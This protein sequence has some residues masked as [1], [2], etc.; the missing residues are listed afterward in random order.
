MRNALRAA[1]V[2]VVTMLAISCNASPQN[3]G[4]QNA[5]LSE[6]EKV[7]AVAA[8]SEASQHV[9]RRPNI[10]VIMADD[11]GYSD[12]AP[13]GGEISTPNLSRL[14][15]EGV[16]FTNFYV[17]PACS[18]TRSMFLSGVDHHVAG[19]GN[20]EFNIQ[21]PQRGRP[22]YEGYLNDSVVSFASLLNDAGYQTYMVGKWHLG[23]DLAHGPENRGFDY[24]FVLPKGSADH[25]SQSVVPGKDPASGARIE[26]RENGES[27]TLPDQFYSSDL[28]TDRL[29]ALM[30]KNRRDDEPFFAYAAYT[31]PHWPL[32]APEE[33]SS[34]YEG[35]YERGYEETRA[36]RF[37][38]MIKMGIVPKSAKA[39]GGLAIWPHWADLSEEQRALE[40]RRMQVFAGMVDALDDNIGRLL[41][42]LDDTG[43][44]DN[45]YVFFLSDN[46][47]EGND[48]RAIG[49]YATWI[50]SFRDNSLENIGEP[51]SF[52]TYG[53]GWGQVSSTPFRLFKGFTTEGGI[54][55]PLIV[56][57]PHGAAPV[58]GG[59]ISKDLVAVTDL[60]P[61]ILDIA[62]VSLPGAAYKGRTV[63]PY[64]GRSI[65]AQI[66]AE[67][68]AHEI[69]PDYLGFELFGRRGLRQGD[70]KLVWGN[71]PYGKDGW[72]L[73]NLKDDPTEQNDLSESRTDIVE[74]LAAVWDDYVKKNGVVLLDYDPVR[75]TNE[76]HHYDE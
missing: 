20:M 69:A 31:A 39:D 27:V 58:A 55:S 23:L 35:V 37:A 50:K 22:G 64:V 40:A 67:D 7:E 63:A 9:N 62:N 75:Y 72:E 73:Y 1:L 49:S 26:Y 28:F 16:R 68:G 3:S 53:P 32:Q 54:R 25:F 66:N 70:W 12:I 57:A 47:A 61:T 52:D 51:T 10:L 46:G 36:Q 76:N 41:Q 34:K 45:T 48:H 74:Q 71:A 21:P 14:A 44:L 60:A 33:Y 43:A 11:L 24:S 65:L 17:A 13:Y 2:S 4:A 30:E 15:D 29:I 5:A 6:G 56:V 59:R 18:P 38:R 19:V 8:N 42:Y